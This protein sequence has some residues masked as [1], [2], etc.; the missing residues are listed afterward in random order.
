MGQIECVPNFSEG[1]R[2]EV[3]DAITDAIR[4]S[5]PVV[6]LGASSDPD[7]NRTV[8]TFVG[9][10]DDV[11]DAAFAGAVEARERIDLNVHEGA[12]PRMGAMDVCPFIPLP[13]EE[14]STCVHLAQRVGERIGTE[15]EI[16]V[17]LYEDAATRP[18]RRNLPAVRKG[19]FEGLRDAIGTDPDRVPDY[20]P[21]RIHPT[22]GATG[23]AAR[24]FLVAY[25][26]NLESTDLDAAKE[27]A[28]AVRE[29]DGGL[30]S[31]KGMGFALEAE[32]CVQV[33]MNLCNYRVS[34][35]RTVF[36]EV[37]RLASERGIDVRESE[38]VGL[39]PAEA[40]DD[41]TA[42]HI[43]LKGFD[44]NAQLLENRIAAA[45]SSR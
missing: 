16:P 39:V 23:V 34:P 20:G 41:E 40:L 38:L 21:E 15:L 7:H 17:Y 25:N 4:A 13:G 5:A 12:H 31:V 8:V 14:M 36:D 27:I 29:R 44:P 26:V 6:F 9:E 37:A 32:G 22:A 11:A 35:I 42:A 3:V 2:P 45:A 30:P 1:R 43:R 10:P 19:Q 33:S 18:E 24:F 28:V